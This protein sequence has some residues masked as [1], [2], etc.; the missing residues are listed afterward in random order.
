[1][2]DQ[3]IKVAHIER[4]TQI[5]ICLD[6]VIPGDGG[7]HIGRVDKTV[8]RE[9]T[10]GWPFIPGTG[11]SGALRSAAAYGQRPSN[12]GHDCGGNHS[13]C[14][15]KST[16]PVCS[17]F[18]YSKG[19][20][21]QKGPVDIL[22]ARMLFFPVES[23]ASVR[24]VTCPEVLATAPAPW[25]GMIP[26]EVSTYAHAD[27]LCYLPNSTNQSLRL[28]WVSITDLKKWEQEVPAE[29]P[30]QIKDLASQLVL[31]SNTVFKALVKSGLDERTSVSINPDSGTAS[32][33]A[34][35]TFEAVP[36][37]TV[38]WSDFV[39]EELDIERQK[40]Q[41]ATLAKAAN[42]LKDLGLGAQKSTGFG[43]IWALSD[44]KAK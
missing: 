17:V 4:L 39:F 36:R 38:F 25:P 21:Q 12:P 32:A 5:W 14:D 29:A 16:C 34:L 20:A 13:E 1:M 8:A 28:G 15:D 9:K 42:F 35:R 23:S 11:L 19:E 41:K 30:T 7:V 6:P 10:T 40:S 26:P 33:G 31:V 22:D 27:T 18:G 44:W 24:W 3:L 2:S 43:R 37:G